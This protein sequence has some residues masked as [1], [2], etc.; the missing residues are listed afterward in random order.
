MGVGDM[1]DRPPSGP[2]TDTIKYAKFAGYGPE[3]RRVAVRTTW[4]RGAPTPH[5]GLLPVSAAGMLQ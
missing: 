3:R 4:S 2:A 5:K 1:V